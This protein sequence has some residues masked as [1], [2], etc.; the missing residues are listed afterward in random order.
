MR[1]ILISLGMLVLHGTA[2]AASPLASCSTPPTLATPYNDLRLASDPRPPGHPVP[3][4]I[5]VASTL[6]RAQADFLRRSDPALFADVTCAQMSKPTY[7][8]TLDNGTHI[9]VADPESNFGG[10]FLVAAFNP[11]TVQATADPWV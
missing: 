7:R 8:I 2:H 5:Q 4:P 9:Y 3:L 6:L 11:R 10:F 1:I